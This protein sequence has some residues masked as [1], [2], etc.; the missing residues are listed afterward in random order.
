[1]SDLSRVLSKIG[2]T[3][4][5]LKVYEVVIGFGFRTAGQINSYCELGY[6][7]VREACES[8]IEKNFLKKVVGKSVEG[9]VYIPLAPKIA[10]SGDVSKNL[11]NQL[12]GLAS[13]IDSLWGQAQQAIDSDT[14]GLVAS[15]VSNLQNTITKIDE[16][17][18]AHTNKIEDIANN[19]QS[20]VSNSI[21][22]STK[23]FQKSI[24]K[25][26]QDLL[27]KL[28][29]LSNKI[30]LVCDESIVSIEN[31]SDQHNELIKTATGNIK[32][33]ITEFIESA[34][35]FTTGRVSGIY[36][37]NEEL[38]KTSA[39]ETKAIIDSLR[40]KYAK[41]ISAD[42]KRIATI[43][44]SLPKEFLKHFK[45]HNV[46]IDQTLAKLNEKFNGLADSVILEAKNAVK[47]TIASSGKQVD[48]LKASQV[49]IIA[50]IQ[51]ELATS[52]ETV[53]TE[54]VTEL[55]NVLTNTKNE[56]LTFQQ[57]VTD[58][59]DMSNENLNTD[60][61]A[62]ESQLK[63]NLGARFEDVKNKLGGFVDNLKSSSTDNVGNITSSVTD[64]KNFITV[65]MKEISDDFAG[66]FKSFEDT[67][68]SQ[69]SDVVTRGLTE[70][71]GDTDSSKEANEANKNNILASM[72]KFS[73]DVEN[74]LNNVKFELK[75]SIESSEVEFKGK[76]DTGVSEYE[77]EAENRRKEQETQILAIQEEASDLIKSSAEAKTKI[78]EIIES[79][80]KEGKDE[81]LVKIKD[82]T[83]SSVDKFSR[84]FSRFSEKLERDLK[85]FY[86]DFHDQT[87][88]L[89]DE[90]PQS[91]ED[92]LVDQSDRLE[93]FR[94]DFERDMG[95]AM[96][97]LKKLETVFMPGTKF[98]YKKQKDEFYEEITRTV[99][100]F[101][102]FEDTLINH[103][104]T[105]TEQTE[106]VKHELL[107]SVNKTI[108]DE[109]SELEGL[110]EN[111]SN[112]S[113]K[114]TNEF[115]SALSNHT[116]EFL[117]D[118]ILGTEESLSTFETNISNQLLEKFEQPLDS[119]LSR[120]QAIATG[121]EAGEEENRILL[122][123]NLLIENIQKA[124]NSLTVALNDAFDHSILDLEAKV[125]NSIGNIK[126]IHTIGTSSIEDGFNKHMTNLDKFVTDFTDAVSKNKS[127]VI[128]SLNKS[129][130]DT[131]QNLESIVSER[132]DEIDDQ[133]NSGI[134]QLQSLTTGTLTDMDKA[135]AG[136]D[137]D[138]AAIFKKVKA[139]VNKTVKSTTKNQEIKTVKAKESLTLTT[140]NAVSKIDQTQDSLQTNVSETLNKVSS[141]VNS[142]TTNFD[143]Q[144]E[145]A[146]QAAQKNIKAYFKGVEKHIKQIA[147]F[148]DNLTNETATNAAEIAKISKNMDM[149]LKKHLDSYKTK[150]DENIVK[151]DKESDKLVT[152]L[153]EELNGFITEIF[154]QVNTQLQVLQ[155]EINEY[156]ETTTANVDLNITN[157]VEG[158][159]GDIVSASS[160]VSNL[161][162]E[163]KTSS[164]A[165]INDVI[166]QI[167]SLEGGDDNQFR[168][169]ETK[170]K[171]EIEQTIESEKQSW[172]TITEQ[173]YKSLVSTLSELRTNFESNILSKSEAGK[174]AVT[175]AINTIPSTIESTLDAAA[176]S[177]ALLNE[178]SQ[179]SINLEAKF[180]ELSYF[181]SSKEGIIANLN[182]I[183]SR[184]K[185]SLTIVSP[186]ISWLDES[187]IEKFSRVAVKIITDLDQ[188]DQED[189]R[190]IKKFSEMGVN[191][192][193]RRLDR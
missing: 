47:E 23:A 144:I 59:L 97:L 85:K 43:D 15:A 121:S 191:L 1:M 30:T 87:S 16:Q 172:K 138:F 162:A 41:I 25:P 66:E 140:D 19:Y 46:T 84:E 170:L 182:A 157:I 17:G 99:G 54:A 166:S 154:D 103:F 14:Q 192:D 147:A 75:A 164:P 55:G 100:D 178:I 95:H 13:E 48:D 92:L 67:V 150:R 133:V 71:Q 187:L 158:V 131:I 2:L 51:K 104:R 93:D 153:Q 122:T 37:Q 155:M 168:Q 136:F 134:K 82:D 38:S 80:M 42:K 102:R 105:S 112:T 28:E 117:D 111:Q 4:S 141:S 73:E 184:T 189:E 108:Q 161:L 107:N 185:A 114:L 188:H 5:E 116:S 143:K 61:L 98:N 45:D 72:D 31:S 160:N 110:V 145:I 142:L 27:S 68:T 113:T 70:L 21:S 90:V 10:I 167:R 35:L 115:I 149:V 128:D 79:G 163:E 173:N 130:G 148:K 118:M 40:A 49:E 44:K 56:L 129:I 77:E 6:Q 101:R 36:Q 183:L 179:G 22:E 63:D 119:I 64:L 165:K 126:Q 88:G 60:L 109:L 124:V 91:I 7:E 177:M 58:N 127:Q 20:N 69:L 3:E 78:V 174:T 8:L 29:E 12:Q 152:N 146:K 50:G 156:V 74:F 33:E 171:T 53:Q 86:E 186:R 18:N 159:R 139:E 34:G 26:L 132:K 9:T 11:S 151:I 94:R 57:S 83:T 193:L 32:E 62:L 176:K 76:V 96:D 65:F 190:I 52:V 169:A 125:D 180:P 24:S 175:N 120:A 135:K 39:N 137:K 123:Q 181:D 106:D 89:R 81:F